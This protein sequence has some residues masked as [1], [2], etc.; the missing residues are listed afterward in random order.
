MKS[1]RTDWQSDVSSESTGLPKDRGDK[2]VSDGAQGRQDELRGLVGTAES[3]P[4]REGAHGMQVKGPSAGAHPLLGCKRLCRYMKFTSNLLMS[5][6]LEEEAP[7]GNG[8][9]PR[10]PPV[11]LPQP[12]GPYSPLLAGR[13]FPS[14]A[15][16]QLVVHFGCL[17]V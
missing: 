15:L 2:E 12:H 8:K 14:L 17:V 3:W 9:C 6:H 11:P 4:G 10:G 1:S 7:Q 16:L 13:E 5:L